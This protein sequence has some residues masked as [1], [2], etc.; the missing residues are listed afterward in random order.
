[1]TL[2]CIKWRPGTNASRRVCFYGTL[3]KAIV[4]SLLPLALGTVFITFYRVLVLT[5][6]NLCKWVHP[7]PGLQH[8][9]TPLTFII[10]LFCPV[11]REVSCELT[12][13][14]VLAIKTPTPAPSPRYRTV[15]LNDHSVSLEK[16]KLACPGRYPYLPFPSLLDG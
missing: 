11:S 13:L 10:L 4:A 12:K 2:T 6:Q 16:N 14:V 7:K 3:G 9:P 5:L 1:M 15:L 8:A